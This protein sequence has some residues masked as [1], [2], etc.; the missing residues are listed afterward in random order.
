M[1]ILDDARPPP[2]VAVG[3]QTL[4]RRPANS[5]TGPGHQNRSAHAP[6][7]SPGI[8]LLNAR[9]M[10]ASLDPP[11]QRDYRTLARNTTEA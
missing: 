2:S 9:P 1:R 8:G 10:V 3:A 4:G 6:L 11:L 7:L 5:G